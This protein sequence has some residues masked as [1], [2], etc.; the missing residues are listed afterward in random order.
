MSRLPGPPEGLDLEGIRHA[1]LDAVPQLTDEHKIQCTAF[2][3][4]G[5]AVVGT[6]WGFNVLESR[7]YR[8][9]FKGVDGGFGYSGDSPYGDS[10]VR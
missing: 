3:E 8:V 9:P 10:T 6:V 2:H 1:S 7:I 4:A 5:H